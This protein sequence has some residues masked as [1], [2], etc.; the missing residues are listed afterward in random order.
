[1][2]QTPITEDTRETL[3]CAKGRGA[4]F[5]TRPYGKLRTRVYVQEPLGGPT[6]GIGVFPDDEAVQLWEYWRELLVDVK[7]TFENPKHRRVTMRKDRRTKQIADQI[8]NRKAE[9]VWE[10][11]AKP[12]Y[13]GVRG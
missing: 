3:R 6:T 5:H 11:L 8:W 13:Y 4:S 10:R 1:M 7:I 9:E 12:D 2:T